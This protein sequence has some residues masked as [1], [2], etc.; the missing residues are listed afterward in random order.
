MRIH[1]LYILAWGTYRPDFAAICPAFSS[2]NVKQRTTADIGSGSN[3]FIH[4]KK[5]AQNGTP[6]LLVFFEDLS[7][8]P[9]NGTRKLEIKPQKLTHHRSPPVIRY[10]YAKPHKRTFYRTKCLK[11]RNLCTDLEFFSGV[12]GMPL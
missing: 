10:N 7:F 11:S 9:D 3:C 5:S 2:V 12:Q 8:F 1:G 6:E 4:L